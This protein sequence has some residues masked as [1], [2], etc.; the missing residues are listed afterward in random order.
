MREVSCE[1][2]P[3]SPKYQA[4]AGTS[5]EWEVKKGDHHMPGGGGTY[6]FC[7][8]QRRGKWAVELTALYPPEPDGGGGGAS[9]G[10]GGGAEPG[11]EPGGG[12]C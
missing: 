9:L 10:G 4:N 7:Q 3:P 11:A 12:D 8:I 6:F 1:F 5:R 2:C